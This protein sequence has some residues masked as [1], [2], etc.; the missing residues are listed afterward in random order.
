MI[1]T[2]LGILLFQEKKGDLEDSDEDGS[3]DEGS[4]EGMK[5]RKRLRKV[6][7]VQEEL[8]DED[9]AL[10]HEAQATARG[11]EIQPKA[12]VAKTE[13]ELRKGLFVDSDDESGVQQE[14]VRKPVRVDR[15][16]E[17]GMDDFIDDD[18]GDQDAIRAADRRD[19]DE[20]EANE[21]SEAQLN[22]ASEIFGTDYLE[23]MQED[24]PD[25]DEEE[26]LGKAKYRERGVGVQYG[27]SDEEVISD[28]D[29]SDD[30]DDDL[31]GDD[32][33]VPNAQK[34][35]SL[36]LKREKRK[37]LKDEKRAKALSKK[38]ERR[39]AQLR[40]A[41]EPVQLIENFCTDKDDEIRQADI[42]ERMFDW[43]TPFY[44]S[45][46]EKMNEAEREQAH[47]IALHIPNV[48][49]EYERATETHQAFILE[50]ISSA[51]KFLHRDKLEP[52][53]IK[54]YRKDYVASATVREH[55][56]DVMEQDSAWDRLV[57][58]KDRVDA[59]VGEIHGMSQ[60]EE[61][62]GADAEKLAKLQEELMAAKAKLEEIAKQEVDVNAQ[63]DALPEDDSDD[64]DN[65]FGDG[66]DNDVRK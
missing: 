42:P 31:F 3:D 30:D 54:R 28:E 11:E 25:Q 7:K 40:R 10:I 1:K 36:R 6:R 16:D 45:A 23:F 53:F 24:E 34:A 13:E 48:A 17:D 49:A 14:V 8:D 61:S 51:L 50:S 27:D 18:I 26:L 65:L 55:L 4:D 47:W 63:L 60:V 58:A 56:Y 35:E 39:K 44:G 22:E 15:Y 46:G 20:G 29:G 52:A 12:V 59:L 38:A 41:F 64:D 19:Y 32:D 62:S 9:M 21:I 57:R 5:E 43:K 2:Q 33:D 37:L 66:M